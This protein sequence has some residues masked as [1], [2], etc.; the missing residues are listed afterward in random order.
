[1]FG[2][3]LKISVRIGPETGRIPYMGSGRVCDRGALFE[4]Q[5][6]T[7][8]LG[9]PAC[10]GRAERAATDDKHIR[11]IRHKILRVDIAHTVTLRFEKFKS[12]GRASAEEFY[13]ASSASQ[14]LTV[15]RGH[16][17]IDAIV[18]SKPKIKYCCLA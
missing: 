5:N 2:R 12:V 9:Q 7:A 11:V 4:D 8:M 18:S 14:C 1:M 17:G 15:T 13:T 16:R 10:Y 3:D 6:R